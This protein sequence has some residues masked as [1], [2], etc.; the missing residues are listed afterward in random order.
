MRIIEPIPLKAG[1]AGVIDYQA[2]DPLHTKENPLFT[3]IELL[4]VDLIADYSGVLP[5]TEY[6][7]PQEYRTDVTQRE[8]MV[9]MQKQAFAKVYRAAHP[10]GNKVEDNDAL[11]FFEIAARE[12]S[13]DLTDPLTIAAFAGFV[14]SNYLTQPEADM[15]LMGVAL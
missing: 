7:A 6:I 14:A 5:L 8:L 13:I 3:N 15:V 2:L 12:Q 4:G 1:T 10:Q 11:F 9:L